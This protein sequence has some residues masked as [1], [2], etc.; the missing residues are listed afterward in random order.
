MATTA[1]EKGALTVREITVADAAVVA[2]LSGQ[3]GYETSAVEMEQR[4]RQV[5]PLRT[6]H[7]ALV[8]C[9][10]GEVVGWIEAEVAYHLQTP[11]HALITGFVVKDGVRSLGVGARLCAEVEAWSRRQG[12]D[13]IRVTSR[14]TR[15]RAHR[16]YL[17]EGYTQIKTSAVFEKTL[18]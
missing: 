15:E 1:T 6:G 14:M 16:F 17:R 12:A 18:Y 4:L 10:N 13:V 9:L 5:L 2:G 11:P 3:L 8:A 7:A